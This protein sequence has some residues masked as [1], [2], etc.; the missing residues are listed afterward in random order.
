[1]FKEWGECVKGGVATL[2]FLNVVSALLVFS[3]LFALFIFIFGGYKYI[4]AAGDPKK[5]E[6]ARNN[7]IYGIIGLIIILL[8]FFI[9]NVVSTVTGVECITKFGFNCSS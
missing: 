6:G 4:N 8:S 1:M 5:L 2:S 7:L 3:G 9:I